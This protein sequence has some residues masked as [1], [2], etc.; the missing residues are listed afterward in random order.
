LTGNLILLQI[1]RGGLYQ[2]EGYDTDNPTG[3]IKMGGITIVT[4]LIMMVAF[5]VPL[6]AFRPLW[7]IY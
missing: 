7:L 4:C 1:N 6:M 2:I 3:L 5:F